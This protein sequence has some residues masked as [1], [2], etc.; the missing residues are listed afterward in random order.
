[1]ER[2]ELG[3]VCGA[4]LMHSLPL[5]VSTMPEQ[6]RDVGVVRRCAELRRPLRFHR[7]EFR[8]HMPPYG[9]G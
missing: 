8:R 4:L 2:M 3:E 1:M 5:H 7:P 9:I 6:S